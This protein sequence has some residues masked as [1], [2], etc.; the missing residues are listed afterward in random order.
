MAP[1]IGDV[2]QL[3]PGTAGTPNTTIESAKY[4]TFINDVA[5]AQNTARPVIGGGTGGITA[6]AGNDGLNT[7]GVDIASGSTTDLSLATGVYV[8]VT[9]TTTIN[10]FGTVAAGA[11]R[12]LTFTGILT[13]THNATSLILPGSANLTTAAGDTA[14]MRSLGSGNWRCVGYQRASGSPITNNVVGA[15]SITGSTAG[16]L[17]TVTSTDAGAGAAPVIDLVRD[18]ASPAASDLLAYLLWTGRDSAAN[19]QAYAQIHAQIIDATSA[20]EDALWVLETVIA[21]TMA[22]RLAIGAG[23]Y[24]PSATGSD[25]GADTINASILYQNGVRVGGTPDAVLEDQKATGTDGGTFTTGAWRTRDLNTKVRDVSSLITLASNQF[26]S[27]VDGWVQWDAPAVNCDAHKTRLYN[28]TDATATAIGTAEYATSSSL[29]SVKSRG[30]APIVAGKTYRIEHICG[31]SKSTI[32]FGG[33]AGAG[34]IEVY[35]RVEFWRTA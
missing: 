21:G 15:M 25:K 30:G 11:E 16:T 8:N 24:T 13:L 6:V 19:L 28:V 4:N 29:I 14:T 18:S 5:T 9:G 17:L 31:N 35:T 26:T 33:A 3:P 27:T 32:G 10:S 34:A 2:Y 20:S 7:K 1:Y 23:I 22:A 12:V